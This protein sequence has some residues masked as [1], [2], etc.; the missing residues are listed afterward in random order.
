M[1]KIDIEK[2]E[3]SFENILEALEEL[4]EKLLQEVI[5]VASGKM[6]KAEILGFIETSVMRICNYA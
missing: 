1:K 5:Q 6:T 2:I 3:R 4:G